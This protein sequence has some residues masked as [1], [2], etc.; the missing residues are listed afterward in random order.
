[1]SSV[2]ETGQFTVSVLRPGSGSIGRLHISPDRAVLCSMVGDKELA[3]ARSPV[4]VIYP[5]LDL[6][7]ARRVFVLASPH[8]P[9][10]VR[11][12]PRSASRLAATL[13]KAG[14]ELAEHRTLVAALPRPWFR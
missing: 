5:R 1:M 2:A 8:G 11:A 14:F 9:Y 6:F 10:G 4:T 7:G 13:Q 3:S 12:R